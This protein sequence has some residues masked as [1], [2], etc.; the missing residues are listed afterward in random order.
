MTDNSPQHTNRLRKLATGATTLA[1]VA[2]VGLY[3]FMSGSDNPLDGANCGQSVEKIAAIEPFMR[4]DLAAFQ[5]TTNSIDL[6]SLAFNDKNGAPVTLADWQG[7]TVLLNLWATWCAPC[8]REMPALEKLQDALGSEAFEVV[9]VSIDL[10]EDTKAKRFY[11]QI[12]LTTLPFYA[13]GTLEIF[14]TLKK[15]GLAFGMPA[16]ILID[17]N[18]CSLA[19]LNGPAEWAGK[20]ARS[21]IKAAI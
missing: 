19:V 4:G 5:P 10:G 18:G 9:P 21:F 11:K 15:H 2:A 3:A 6:S 8:R 14:N 17:K 7:R 13:D 20:D 16:T 1:V 12:G